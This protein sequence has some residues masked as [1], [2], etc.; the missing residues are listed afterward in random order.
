MHILP[1]NLTA[2][3]PVAVSSGLSFGVR[4][5]SAMGVSV[6][7]DALDY[8]GSPI[9]AL[10]VIGDISD[11]IVMAIL[12]RLTGSK[13]S[14]VINAIEFIP[15][16]GDFIPTYTITTL[17]W[18]FKE[19]RKEKADYKSQSLPTPGKKIG[20][21]VHEE[22][23]ILDAGSAHIGTSGSGQRGP[24]LQTRLMRAYAVLRSKA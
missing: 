3:Q 10:P 14:A 24:N 20:H 11:A 7:A 19:M 1:V 4:A 12:Y 5:A 6:V 18:I 17:M 2:K 13:R 9:F 15:F 23:V 8:V 16:V 22:S 21:S